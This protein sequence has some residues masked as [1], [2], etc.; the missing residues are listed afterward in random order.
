M[1]E[2]KNKIK[3]D[4]LNKIL[5]LVT[6]ILSL[7]YILSFTKSCSSADKREKVKT[8]LVNPKYRD[9][10]NTIILQDSA[11]TLEL[12]NKEGFWTLQKLSG[13]FT[14]APQASGPQS[15]ISI[16]A[17]TQRVEKLLEELIKVR[18]LY[19]ISDKINKNSSLGLTNG[20]E[21]HI[22]Y[23]CKGQNS[24]QSGFRELIFGNQD[25]SL[26]SRYM[27]T[28]E[29]TQVYEIDSSLDT[30]LTS[31]I[32]SW[33]EAY[34]ISRNAAPLLYTDI[35]SISIK[36]READGNVSFKKITGNAAAAEKLLELRHGGLP[37]EEERSLSIIEENLME[38]EVEKGDKSRINLEIKALTGQESSYLVELHYFKADSKSAFY[39][40]CSK[41]SGW[42]YNKIKEITL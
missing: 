35:Q 27:M 36:Q 11:A 16:P 28:G 23:S 33:S 18:N 29:S 40:S 41:I 4:R 6:L 3:A 12:S 21:F 5:L 14:S 30:F 34:I 39:N 25:F 20:T 37:T 31:S 10:I 19:K 7:L 24:E 17:D 13:P 38:I 26:S 1:S 22:S 32:Q 8:A 42:T 2:K 9:E 15:Q